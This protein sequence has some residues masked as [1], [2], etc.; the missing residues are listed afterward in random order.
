VKPSEEIRRI[1]ER[2]MQAISERDSES[3]LERVS[4]L[5]GALMVGTDPEEWF[6]GA[7]AGPAEHGGPAREAPADPREPGTERR[8]PR[9]A[10]R[11]GS[12]LLPRMAAILHW[13]LPAVSSPSNTVPRH[14]IGKLAGRCRKPCSKPSPRRFGGGPG[15]PL[16]GR[17]APARPSLYSEQ[18]PNSGWSWPTS[19]PFGFLSAP[20]A[21]VPNTVSWTISWR[22][23]N[24]T[25]GAW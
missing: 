20:V 5:P 22:F 6:R 11:A 8:T 18:V 25:H 4:D 23:R 7:E 10:G 15:G 21:G 9:T 16:L 17:S 14:R 3:S 19:G 2:W 1:V 13:N 12:C 24:A